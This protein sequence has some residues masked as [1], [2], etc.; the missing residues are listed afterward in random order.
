MAPES[1]FISNF[2][3]ALLGSDHHFTRSKCRSYFDFEEDTSG[4]EISSNDFTTSAEHSA[5][6]SID[7]IGGQQSSITYPLLLFADFPSLPDGET[8]SQLLQQ[9]QRIFVYSTPFFPSLSAALATTPPY[10][11]VSRA[12]LGASV[13]GDVNKASWAEALQR[14]AFSLLNGC[15]EV[16]N[17]LA[18][19]PEWIQAVSVV[20]WPRSPTSVQSQMTCILY[21]LV[22]GISLFTVVD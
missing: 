1:G 6:N 8:L 22:Q 21:R 15:I 12:L 13:S 9:Y 4:T 5:I 2:K 7:E 19:K 3:Q 16:D 18:R 14:A 10:L 20:Y 11:G 17:S